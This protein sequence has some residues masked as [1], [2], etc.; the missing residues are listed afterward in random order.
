MSYVHAQN[1][2]S[3]LTPQARAG[4]SGA[5]DSLRTG[6]AV[7]HPSQPLGPRDREILVLIH[8]F[9]G[10]EGVSPTLTDI[11]AISGLPN[12]MVQRA[13]ARLLR[14]NAIVRITAPRMRPAYLPVHFTAF[15]ASA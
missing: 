8:L 15:Q 9:R 1:S 14:R 10:L 7:P 4:T 11:A 5:A 6:S 2:L 12:W 13:V 3:A